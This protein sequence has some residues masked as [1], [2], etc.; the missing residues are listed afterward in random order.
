[1]K[2]D[3]E[4]KRTLTLQKEQERILALLQ[5]QKEEEEEQKRRREEAE[6]EESQEIKDEEA[7]RPEVPAVVNDRLRLFKESEQK[8]KEEHEVCSDI[9]SVDV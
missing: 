2:R 6:A 4:M 8:Q 9:E 5:K 7:S 3:G 1:M